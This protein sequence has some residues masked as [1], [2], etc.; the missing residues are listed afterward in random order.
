VLPAIFVAHGAP[1]LAVDP[2]R[3][4]PLRRW[5]SALPRPKAILGISAHWEASPLS[6]SALTARD[7]EYDFWGFPE[8]LY[9][10][11]YPAPPAPALAERVAGLLAP[12]QVLRTDRGIDHGVWTPLVHMFPKADVPVL[13]LSMPLSL[14]AAALFAVGKALR[15]LRDEGV[16]LLGSGNLVH[17]LRQVDWDEDD[18]PQFW[19]AEFDAWIG[20][21]LMRRDWD[22]LL[23]YR[24]RAP[25]LRMA[26]P[27]EEH[28]RPVLVVAGAADDA[29]VSF[30]LIGWEMGSV[31]RR[32]VQFG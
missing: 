5:G 3:G 22:A 2:V 24:K 25:Q 7:L 9:K 10:V 12:R 6:L 11:R 17:N 8:E 32:S 29:S 13:Q 31:S 15:P 26:H 28:F 30:P 23:D 21:V 14:D 4:E 18:P 27:T 20:N 16:L 19:A 1:L